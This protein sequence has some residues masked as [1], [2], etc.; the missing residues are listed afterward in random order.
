M[1]EL[2]TTFFYHEDYKVA[3]SDIA[4]TNGVEKFDT[5]NRPIVDDAGEIKVI[6]DL[7]AFVSTSSSCVVNGNELEARY[8]SYRI[9]R[10]T[11]GAK[12]VFNF[13]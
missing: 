3:H 11:F 9:A 6:D 13:V 8:E 5:D 12:N 10:E 2:V 7:I 1:F 4:K